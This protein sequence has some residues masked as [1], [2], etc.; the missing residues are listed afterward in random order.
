MVKG[1]HFGTLTAT[2]SIVA[3]IPFIICC[4][5]K[6]GQLLPLV[7]GLSKHNILENLVYNENLH[8]FYAAQYGVFATFIGLF[9]WYVKKGYIKAKL[10]KLKKLIKQWLKKDKKGPKLLQT[11]VGEDQTCI[12]CYQNCRNVIFTQC[13]HFLI[14]RQC[15]YDENNHNI[16]CPVCRN[17]IGGVVEVKECQRP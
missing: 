7:A 8:L 13:K 17:D 14:C 12:I 6:D 9:V 2:V 4:E 10:E 16:A 5:I 1:P 15:L 11:V 3:N